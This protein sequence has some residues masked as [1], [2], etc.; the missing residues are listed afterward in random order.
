MGKLPTHFIRFDRREPKSGL[1]R[2][3]RR[4]FGDESESYQL[5]LEGLA[6][7]LPVVY[8][9]QSVASVNVCDVDVVDE[10]L[11]KL[12]PVHLYSVF[13]E[14]REYLVELTFADAV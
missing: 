7:V 13:T 12:P 11:F 9:N 2:L 1:Y 14:D 5:D 10:V 8:C 3:F 6:M 4:E